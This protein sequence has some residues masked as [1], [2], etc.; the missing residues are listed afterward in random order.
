M[1]RGERAQA[2]EP[3][4]RLPARHAGDEQRAA[5]QDRQAAAQPRAEVANE[6]E[7]DAGQGDRADRRQDR[8]MDDERD[9][10]RGQLAR[11][12]RD[13]QPPVGQRPGHE[14]GAAERLEERLGH[15]RGGQ[16]G[17]ARAGRA[18]VDE[19]ELDDVAAA[20][21][22]DRVEPGAGQ[23]RAHHVAGAQVGGLGIG[24]AQD[25]VPA[26][27]TDALGDEVQQRAQ[28]EPTG[29]DPCGLLG[30]QLARVRR[31]AQCGLDPVDH[32]RRPAYAVGDLAAPSERSG[33]RNADTAVTIR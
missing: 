3:R 7:G 2:D 24:G 32:P 30:D 13:R 8:V 27:R 19:R 1:Q 33:S 18:A 10:E 17:V 5:W 29:L 11:A 25:R 6:Q 26:A 16:R 4:E 20:G 22:D 28:H 14:R 9:V 12:G 31:R 23:V 15:E 21:R